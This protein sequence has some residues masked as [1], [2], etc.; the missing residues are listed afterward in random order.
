MVNENII[1][2]VVLCTM[3]SAVAYVEN[4]HEKQKIAEK[5]KRSDNEILK[6]TERIKFLADNYPETF[7]EINYHELNE[8]KLL[9]NKNQL[10]DLNKR[11]DKK[12][13]N[14]LNLIADVFDI[15]KI[16]EL[17]DTDYLYVLNCLSPEKRTI[18]EKLKLEQFE[19]YKLREYNM[20]FEAG[21]KHRSI[22]GLHDVSKSSYYSKGYSDS[23]YEHS[24]I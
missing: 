1:F 15:K 11:L 17:N 10:N 21:K 13:K 4:E 7:D 8:V 22:Y 16:F 20:G 19:Y 23:Y 6:R 12:H 9:L 14:K 24:F 18:I 5:Q 3:F 2:P